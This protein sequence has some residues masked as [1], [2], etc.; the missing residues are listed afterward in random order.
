MDTF[1]MGTNFGSILTAINGVNTQL[2][3]QNNRKLLSDKVNKDFNSLIQNTQKQL[4]NMESLDFSVVDVSKVTSIESLIADSNVK[5]LNLTG[6]SWDSTDGSYM[7]GINAM[8]SSASNLEVLDANNMSIPRVTML[9]YTGASG[10]TD[11]KSIKYIKDNVR[12][13]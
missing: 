12:T 11:L 5:E 13:E 7:N 9:G 1:D 6:L 8:L 4:K 3:Q 2:E 10:W